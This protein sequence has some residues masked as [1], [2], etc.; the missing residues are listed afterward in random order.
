MSHRP[1]LNP[2]DAGA[3]S[4]VASA[5]AA[6]AAAIVC[7]VA[8]PTASAIGEAGPQT[9]A[10]DRC[11]AN[12]ADRIRQGVRSG[13]LTRPEA[14][15]LRDGQA[16]LRRHERWARADGEVSRRERAALQHEANQQNRRIYRQKHDAQDR[17]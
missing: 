10:L 12:Q 9:P 4:R 1:T 15:R 6:V 17:H 16:D 13:E 2:A 8:S 3:P 14:R 11:E 7:A 5:L